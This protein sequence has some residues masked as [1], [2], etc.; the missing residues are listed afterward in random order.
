MSLVETPRWPTLLSDV[1][2]GDPPQLSEDG[3]PTQPPRITE[4]IPTNGL[5]LHSV[6]HHLPEGPTSGTEVS[7]KKSF[8]VKSRAPS[9]LF[10]EWLWELVMWLLGTVSLVLIVTLL[11]YFNKKPLS[12][13]R[14]AITL[15]TIIAILSQATVSALLVS[16][17]AC[18][19]QLKWLWLR[20]SNETR[21]VDTF[22]QAS[23]GPHGSLWFLWRIHG[24]A[25]AH[26]F[27]EH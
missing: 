21:D 20:R 26:L 6:H 18:I 25:Y 2:L 27:P 19:G 5:V 16:V 12:L 11:A 15:N 22:D 1:D 8:R 13:W 3:P 17:S 4:V 24:K 23:R 14:S 10:S 9:T 7:D